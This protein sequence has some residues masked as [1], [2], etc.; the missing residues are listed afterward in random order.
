[1]IIPAYWYVSSNLG[2]NLTP[3][4]IRKMGATACYVPLEDAHGKLIMSGS[5]LSL[6]DGACH[7]WGAGLGSLDQT[8]HPMARIHAVRGP[9]S[10]DR[11]LADGADCPAIYGDP[12]L[13]VPRFHTASPNYQKPI[14]L[15]PHFV[16]QARVFPV[17]ANSPDIQLINILDSVET[18]ADQ[19]AGCRFVVSSALHGI[20]L[21]VAYRVPFIWAVFSDRV[22]GEGF[23]FHDFFGSLGLPV[24][25]PW[26]LRGPE[27]P[28]AKEMYKGP[29][30]DAPPH[31]AVVE[32]FWDARPWDL[33]SL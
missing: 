18:V 16:D 26:D 7:V 14:G 15:V 27:L 11:A 2:D 33:L 19:I 4:L 17:Y 5:I 25:R 6:A 8:V 9:L 30:I 10:R 29:I 28:S 23:K 22:L 24:M 1:M 13:L 20:I 3:W 21:A 12:G 31:N 32:S